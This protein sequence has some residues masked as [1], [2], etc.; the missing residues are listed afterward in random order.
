LHYT[1]SVTFGEP[2]ETRESVEEKLGFLRSIKP[3]MANLRIGVSVLPGTD[4]AKTALAEGL[5]AD[6]SEL[7]KPTFYLAESVQDW[8]VDYLQEAKAKH[9]RWNLM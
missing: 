3:A 2:G 9:P 8:I 4:V 5:I 7:I 1:L 6:E